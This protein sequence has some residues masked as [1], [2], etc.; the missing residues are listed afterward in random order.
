MSDKRHR[1]FQIVTL[2]SLVVVISPSLSRA[3]SGPAA[4]VKS[5]RVAEQDQWQIYCAVNRC[6]HMRVVD[7][8]VVGRYALA[9]WED[10]NQGGQSLLRNDENRWRRIGHGG[11]V[12]NAAVLEGYGVPH[13]IAVQLLPHR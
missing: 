8:T 2:A 1:Y 9:T 7:V 11:G 4:D 3:D 10:D 12:M 6:S 13:A 5:A